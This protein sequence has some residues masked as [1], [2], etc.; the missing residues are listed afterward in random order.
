MVCQKH[1]LL[2]SFIGKDNVCLILGDNFFYGQN[3][4][5]MLLDSTRLKRELKFF[6]S[7]KKTKLIRCSKN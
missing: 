1:L 2:G 4:S 7:S 5:K 3:L 6:T